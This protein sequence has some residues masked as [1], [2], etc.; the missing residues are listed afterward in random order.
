[1]LFI[2]EGLADA[3][4]TNMA[5]ADQALFKHY[6]ERTTIYEGLISEATMRRK[7]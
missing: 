7:R 4:S 6:Q 2:A 1:M 5:M 3:G